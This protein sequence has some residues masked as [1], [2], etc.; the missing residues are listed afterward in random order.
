[1]L[2]LIASPAPCPAAPPRAHRRSKRQHDQRRGGN[3]RAGAD[4]VRFIRQLE[5]QIA[6]WHSHGH[7]G[8]I[9]HG[10]ELSM[11]MATARPQ[12]MVALAGVHCTRQPGIQFSLMTRI[13]R[14]ICYVNSG[15]FGP[16]RV[17][18]TSPVARRRAMPSS[19]AAEH[20]LVGQ[21]HDPP[22][23][24]KPRR[25]RRRRVRRQPGAGSAPVIGAVGGIC[26]L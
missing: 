10:R 13:R 6:F 2:R 19:P 23:V 16:S 14:Q 24:A 5:P 3:G 22:A 12:R 4:A 21:N 1:M 15:R 7:K 9:T 26:T 17:N 8:Q 20:I 18:R 25:P 11:P